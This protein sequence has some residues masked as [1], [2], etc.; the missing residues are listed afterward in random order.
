[1]MNGPVASILKEIYLFSQM[2]DDE[3]KALINI[4]FIQN[5][6]KDSYVFME[7]ETSDYLL[8]L[9]EGI[10]S[11]FKHDDKGN[12]IIMGMF[13]PFSLIAEAAILKGIA[14]PSTAIFKS[15]GSIIKIKIDKFKELFLHNP[16][17]SYEI[18]QSLLGKIQLL[19]Q[20]IH[21]NIATSAKEKILYFYQKNINTNIELKKYEIASLL[22]MTPET[23]S[24]NI[25]H[26]CEEGKIRK[27]KSGY[28][29]I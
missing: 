2:N 6:K 22:G 19:Q 11:I 13:S 25:K 16:H 24:R 8:I 17:I 14:F 15:D 10:V 27:I 12:E 4:S 5:Y 21:F 20:N 3:L 7:G 28:Q 26:L 1:M 23:L 29:A 9:I 18:I